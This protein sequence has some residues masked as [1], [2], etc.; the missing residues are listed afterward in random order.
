MKKYLFQNKIL[1][2]GVMISLLLNAFGELLKAKMMGSLL[3]VGIDRVN[4]DIIGLLGSIL[5]TVGIIVLISIVS[6]FVSARFISY[7]LGKIKEDWMETL[8]QK[9]INAFREKD[10]STYLSNFT[11]DINLFQ[12]DYFESFLSMM[13]YILSFVVSVIAICSVHYYFLLF[14][15]VTCWIPG[16]IS[17]AFKKK[18]FQAQKNY[19]L[20]S[21]NFIL[22]TQEILDAFEIIRHYQISRVMK[23][24]WERKNRDLENSRANKRLFGG[25]CESV[26]FGG[27]LIIWLGNLFFGVVLSIYGKIQVGQILEVSQLLNNVVNP[28]YQISTFYTK[29]KSCEELYLELET[30]YKDGICNYVNEECQEA[31][32]FDKTLNVVDL[33]VTIGGKP[34]LSRVN[35]TFEKGKKY[36][37]VGKSGSGKTTFIKALM[38]Y[39]MDMDGRMELDGQE[40]SFSPAWYAMVSMVYQGTVFLNDTIYNN[41]TLYKTYDRKAVEKLMEKVNLG[42]MLNHLVNGL[43]TVIE[44]NGKN[45]SGG[46]GQRLAIARALIKNPQIIL[47]DEA[48]SALDPSLTSEIEH[49]LLGLEGKTVISI[50]HKLDLD[51]LRQYDEV[52]V[53]ENGTIVKHGTC[54]ELL[55]GYYKMSGGKTINLI[56]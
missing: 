53:F 2:T 19:S 8:L 49:L 35:I 31:L 55:K 29:M 23:T 41:I 42:N 56:S 5:I 6:E 40:I 1:F 46:E 3:Q 14:I 39:Y 4:F 43:D 21:Q 50:T 32:N 45:V 10:T 34:I 51:I 12:D 30:T 28:L 11:S 48:T 52:I 9:Q 27:S 33:S 22:K 26:G 38:G 13:R 37:I 20:N 16:A 44:E 36:V 24:R 17:W 7:S 47:V 15:A 18:L 25:I 54:D